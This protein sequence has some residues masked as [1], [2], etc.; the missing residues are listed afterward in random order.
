M[1]TTNMQKQPVRDGLGFLGTFLRK[2]ASVGAVL[3]SSRYLA[4][5]MAGHLDL[6]AGDLVLEYGPGTGPI[7]SVIAQHLP[8]GAHYLG[9]ELEPRFHDLLQARYP[10]LQ[11]HLG[12]AADAARIL[13]ERGLPMPR[14]IISGLPFASLPHKVQDGIVRGI[15]ECLQGGG[16][17]R[18][19]QYA[20]AYGLKA[21]RRFRRMM[22]AVFANFERSGPVFRNVP[23]AFVLRYWGAK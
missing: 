3:P 22:T 15:A 21:A 20:H 7:T 9:I 17:F 8:A 11:F 23:P 19:F 14:R 10:Q 13:R 12:S 6:H 18:T 16:D 4:R 5:A 1:T 2:P